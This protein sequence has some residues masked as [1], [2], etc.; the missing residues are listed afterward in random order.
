MY[1]HLCTDKYKMGKT[2]DIA[3]YLTPEDLQS[4]LE[5]KTICCVNLSM[6][7]LGR[8]AIVQYLDIAIALKDKRPG[9]FYTV[10]K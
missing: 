4:I 7:E 2:E 9:S 10:Y 8:R 3:I 5:K 6:S 1:V